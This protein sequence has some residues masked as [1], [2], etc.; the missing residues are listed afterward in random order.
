MRHTA[1]SL[2]HWVIKG[3]AST[4]F[5]ALCLGTAVA[6]TSIADDFQ[7]LGIAQV[8]KKIQAP[9]VTLTTTAGETLRLS[10]LTG[11]VVLLNF[12]ATW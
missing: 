3:L 7:T 1:F 4:L 6:E 10:D 11:K 8:D 5:W 9:D 12:W 2:R